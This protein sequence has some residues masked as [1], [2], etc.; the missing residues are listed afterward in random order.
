MESKKEQQ[1]AE[2]KIDIFDYTDYRKLLKDLYE[3][4]KKVN[5]YFSYRFIGQRVG[6]ASAGFFTNIMQGKRN[7]SN[8]IIF[9]FCELFK[10]NKKESEYF[11]LLVNFDQAEDHNRKRYYFERMLTM[12]KS[13]V[14]ELSADQYRYFDHWYNVAIRE[15]LNYYPFKGDFAELARM[16]NPPITAKEA[17]KA[18]A[19]L[20]KLELIRKNENGIYEVT[21]KTVTTVPN[22]P[23]LAIHNFQL[24]AMDLGKEAIDRFPRDERSISTL[25]I[26]TSKQTFKA[27]EEKLAA[28]RREVLE[29]VKSDPYL[30]ERVYQFNFQI[31]PMTADLPGKRT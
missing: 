12:R 2:E 27:I 31:F 25:T 11:E 29:L 15:L 6:F 4:R 13:T 30:I 17:K 7:I 9:K 1:P 22:V 10:F 5:P 8:N 28:F 3:T 19:L 24:A 20:E 14:H 16:L 23:L 18:V 26:S 21:E